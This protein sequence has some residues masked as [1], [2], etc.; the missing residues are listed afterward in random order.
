MQMTENLE[1][2]REID[3]ALDP[4]PYNGGTTTCDALWMGVPVVSLVGQTAVARAGLS[5]LSNVQLSDL[6]ATSEEQY[7]DIATA[8]ATDLQRLAQIR[9]NLR[10]QMLISPLMDQPYF[11]RS[12]EAAYRSVWQTWCLGTATDANPTS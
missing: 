4:F 11:A 8:L 12:V 5:L 3:I 1:L 2:Y 6:A 7:I 9:A 10:A